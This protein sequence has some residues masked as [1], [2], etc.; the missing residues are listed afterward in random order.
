MITEHSI[1]SVHLPAPPLQRDLPGFTLRHAVETYTAPVKDW[2]SLTWS[3][4]R[5]DDALATRVTIDIES[6]TADTITTALYIVHQSP[7]LTQVRHT[8]RRQGSSWTLL[9]R[10][11]GPEIRI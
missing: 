4:R 3:H 1:H 2:P 6:Q 9:R 10:E 5:S 11:E 8:F 7:N